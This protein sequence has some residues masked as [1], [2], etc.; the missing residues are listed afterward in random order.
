M[1]GIYFT[2][3][4]G[5]EPAEDF[6]KRD[7]E[8]TWEVIRQTFCLPLSKWT[9]QTT[10]Y[11]LHFTASC[12]CEGATLDTRRYPVASCDAL[13]CFPTLLLKPA[14]RAQEKMNALME[15]LRW[16]K[17]LTRKDLMRYFSPTSQPNTIAATPCAQSRA[18]WHL[19]FKC[20]K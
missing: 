5:E 17:R 8:K 20:T 10:A 11:S 2:H 12:W 13:G 4:C 7:L 1:H 6:W 3:W 14:K 16:K 19:L 15:K 9:N 18:D